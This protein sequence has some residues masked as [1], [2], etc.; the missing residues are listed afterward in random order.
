[1]SDRISGISSMATRQLLADLAGAYQERSGI[2]VDF[3]TTLNEVRA[4]DD[5]DSNRPVAP[6][7]P[8]PDSVTVDTTALDVNQVVDRLLD[9]A[10][11]AGA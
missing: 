10:R 9:I 7:K 4:R 1:M 6:L 11:A 8:A 5:Q 3:E 2:A